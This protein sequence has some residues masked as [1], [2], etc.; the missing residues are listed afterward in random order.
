MSM[1]KQ[2]LR[3]VVQAVHLKQEA[4]SA[5]TIAKLHAEID[6]Q[7]EEFLRNGGTIKR[8]A[9]GDDALTQRGRDVLRI[10][11]PDLY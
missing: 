1:T 11:N 7:V 6:N 9:P 2:E 4:R 10:F 5:E 8:V 3:E